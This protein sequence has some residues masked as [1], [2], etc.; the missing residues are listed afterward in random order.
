[1]NSIIESLLY[2]LNRITVSGKDNMIR[3]TACIDTLE[4]LKA[5]YKDISN[6]AKA[7]QPEA[8]DKAPE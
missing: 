6:P 5:A 7:A 2:S 4:Q 1:M 3:L 8:E